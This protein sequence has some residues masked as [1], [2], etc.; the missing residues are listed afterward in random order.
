M[1]TK[2]R[3][4]QVQSGIVVQP[5]KQWW[6]CFNQY[7]SGRLLGVEPG[8]LLYLEVSQRWRNREA[9][10]G[11][12]RNFSFDKMIQPFRNNDIHQGRCKVPFYEFLEKD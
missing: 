2:V 8:Y 9:L 4:N 3:N 7:P 5:M 6:S 1:V 11:D 12:S 10:N